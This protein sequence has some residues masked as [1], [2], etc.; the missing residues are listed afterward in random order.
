MVLDLGAGMVVFVLVPSSNFLV[1]VQ[2]T[3]LL[4]L[5]AT[6]RLP[7]EILQSQSLRMGTVL[8]TSTVGLQRCLRSLWR[9]RGL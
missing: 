7:P 8:M 5:L 1:S 2:A 3:L 9:L 6:H 4:L